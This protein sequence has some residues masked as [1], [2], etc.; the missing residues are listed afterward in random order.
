MP[1]QLKIIVDE[2]YNKDA[3]FTVNFTAPVIVSPGNKIALDKFTAVI[4]NI[5]SNFTL[6]DTTFKFY[7]SLNALNF[8]ESDVLIPGQRYNNVVDLLNNLTIG[9]NDTFSAY[10]TGY[11]PAT[12]PPTV[13]RDLGLKVLCTTTTNTS[14]ATTN[15]FQIQY[16][17]SSL[18]PLVMN[19]N[20]MTAG[21][22]QFFYPNSSDWNMVQV[23]LNPVT[24]LKGGGGLVRFQFQ[25]PT[26]I[27]AQ[28]NGCNWS[29]GLVGSDG[30]S[31][32][33]FQNGLGEVFLQNGSSTIQVAINNFPRSVVG[34]LQRYCEIYQVDGNFTLRYFTADP[35]NIEI[36]TEI[37]NSNTLTPGALGTLSYITDYVFQASGTNE[38]LISAVP[39]ISNAVLMTPDVTFANSTGTTSRTV[40]FDMSQS[41]SLRAG[42]DVPAGLNVLT[43]LSSPAGEFTCQ[44]SINMA[45][46]NSSFDIAIEIL[47][48]PLQTYQAST[49]RK[50][51]QRNNVVAYFHPEYSQVGTSTYIYD[52][53]AYQ[54][55]DID[56]T[57]PLNLSSLT[58]RVYD[59]DTGTGLDAL[60]MS[61]NLLIGNVEY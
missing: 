36:Q 54:W 13:Y 5:S 56:V 51:G 27:E 23:P 60:S 28:D 45:I 40:A 47:D 25:M 18:D 61:F 4:N 31:H 21:P 3:P 41:G 16:M 19:E 14:L 52:S 26:A 15:T 6:P 30:A 55:L 32:G 8:S 38:F 35:D 44:S 39:A 37:Y 49:S 50:P 17:T 12:N 57:Y 53:R 34:G 48:L 9:C 20:F 43:P 24:F 58:F 10:R 1:K 46:V 2:N 7:Y 33:L 42:L 29:I 59:P 22:G 11:L